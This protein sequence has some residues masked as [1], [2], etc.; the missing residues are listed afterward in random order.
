MKQFK[1]Y[2]EEY[3]NL[4]EKYNDKP[5]KWV[6]SGF[7][8]DYTQILSQFNNG[9]NDYETIKDYF[10]GRKSNRDNI[11][12][13][14]SI[15]KNITNPL[16]FWSLVI[17]QYALNDFHTDIH[18]KWKEAFTRY[19]R[20][21]VPLKQRQELSLATSQIFGK[22]M[23]VS[24]FKENLHKYSGKKKYIKHMLKEQMKMA[25][26][27]VKKMNKTLD[28]KLKKMDEIIVYRGQ[29]IG[30]KDDMRVGRNK[31]NNPNAHKQDS[32][33]GFSYT[34]DKRC[35]KYF[36][37]LY[38]V[39][40]GGIIMGGV[41]NNFIP[42]QYLPSF[43]DNNKVNKSSVKTISKYSVK[44]ENILFY[45]NHGE[46]NE[47][48]VLPSD[49]ELKHYEIINATRTHHPKKYVKNDGGIL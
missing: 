4:I 37:N 38:Q 10:D 15:E 46:E 40:D 42:S 36:A 43:F 17:H 11:E 18:D 3:E 44:T 22:H 14:L 41:E 5:W 27:E 30:E 24:V 33:V 28:K 23:G 20:L 29:S 48:V 2:K 7:D 35:A 31:L 47:I 6:P 26:K 8:T 32:G 39:R 34:L 9:A 21:E 13:F 45:T 49:V 16:F 25:V 19:D 1:T 12:D